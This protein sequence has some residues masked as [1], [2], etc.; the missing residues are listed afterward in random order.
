MDWG[1]LFLLGFL[2]AWEAHGTDEVTQVK[3][4]LGGFVNKKAEKT[5][6]PQEKFAKNRIF[7]WFRPGSGASKLQVIGF[8]WYGR[9]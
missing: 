7:F 4:A 8:V 2:G 1:L 9:R 3:R 6:L 5:P